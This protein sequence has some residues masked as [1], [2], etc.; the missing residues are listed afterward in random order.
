MNSRF[1]GSVCL[2]IGLLGLA[3][4][5]FTAKGT[6]EPSTF[7]ALSNAPVLAPLAEDSWQITYWGS[8]TERTTSEFK[9]TSWTITLLGLPKDSD[10][11]R[12]VLVSCEGLP[13][14]TNDFGTEPEPATK[15]IFLLQ[16]DGDGNLHE[17]ISP[18]NLNLTS[19]PIDV[20]LYPNPGSATDLATKPV[21]GV[22]V[23]TTSNLNLRA[24]SSS[25]Q[26]RTRT[27]NV[28]GETT[29]LSINGGNRRLELVYDFDNIR[30]RTLLSQTSFY[31]DGEDIRSS[32]KLTWGHEAKLTVDRVR[33]LRQDLDHWVQ[34]DT[35]AQDSI[36]SASTGLN[37]TATS[38]AV[39]M[40]ERFSS[41]TKDIALC[42]DPLTKQLLEQFSTTPG[43]SYHRVQLGFDAFN[44]LRNNRAMS[45]WNATD[46]DGRIYDASLFH[47][48]VTVLGFVYRGTDSAL[49]ATETLCELRKRLSPCDVEVLVFST[50]KDESDRRQLGGVMKE[51]IK[52]LDGRLVAEQLRLFECGVPIIII[53]DQQGQLRSLHACQTQMTDEIVL[54]QVQSI[55]N[56]SEHQHG[57]SSQVNNAP[58]TSRAINGFDNF[59]AASAFVAI[60]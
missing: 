28:V 21:A 25:R 1:Q 23:S 18:K 26:D 14:S 31:D 2:T 3:G 58:L 44:R 49:R 8:S 38:Y 17:L 5:L 41:V 59:D 7:A 19:L 54:E 34:F 36:R 33:M 30:P 51:E 52:V 32:V 22:G 50:D 45:S 37:P 24:I 10:S 35:F 29:D 11:N 42:R 20:L 56:E 55:L 13:M 15:G 53:C 48:K 9:K 12:Q 4:Y 46:L 16:I 43:V 57:W 47:G 39:A 40:A 27:Y 60:D 6:A